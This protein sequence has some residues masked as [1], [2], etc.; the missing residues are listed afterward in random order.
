MLWLP[1]SATY[2]LTPLPSMATPAGLRNLAELPTAS[3]NP[4]DTPPMLPPPAS[5]VTAAPER[6]AARMR[7]FAESAMYAVPPPNLLMAT[8]AG[9]RNVAAEPAPLALPRLMP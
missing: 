7:L 6:A 2:R 1:V 8:P 3:V 5:V 4:G 9:L